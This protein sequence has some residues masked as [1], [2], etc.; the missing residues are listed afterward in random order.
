MA[1]TKEFDRE[2]ALERA[3]ELFWRQGYATTSTDDLVKAMGIGRQ[4]LYDTFGDKQSLYFEA[5]RRYH[6]DYGQGFPSRPAPLRT[7]RET[8]RDALL[9][10]IDR[11]DEVRAKG[12]MGI[13]ATTG[14]G[15]SAPQVEQMAQATAARAEGAFRSIVELGV[16]AGEFAADLDAEAAGRFLYAA[17]QGLTVR[18]QAGA[19][20][21]SLR[22]AVDFAMRSLGT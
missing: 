6:A 9:Q 17:L 13:N 2:D 1:R 18:S 11:P 19:G 15:G 22:S 12:C 14:F 20:A 4:S 5:L 8:I 7:A 16:E 10:V 3:M 21:G